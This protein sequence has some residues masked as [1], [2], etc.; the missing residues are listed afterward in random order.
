[1]MNKNNNQTQTCKNI[2]LM[3]GLISAACVSAKMTVI[4]DS[5][6][7]KSV[8]PYM[9]TVKTPN[10]QVLRQ[11]ASRLKP[12]FKNFSRLPVHTATLTPGKVIRKKIKQPHLRNPFFIV[13]AD[14]LSHQWL[15]E[16]KHQLKTLHAIGIAVNV[17]TEQQLEALQHSAGGI[18][19]NP[20]K[21]G[22]MAQQLKLTH[23][24]ALVSGGLI[25]Q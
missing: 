13:G 23:Y 10:M 17:Q 11:K 1:M 7:T 5:R 21:G 22:K 8:Q 20:V 2:I 16:N 19:I 15:I 24:P 6:L 25:E 14:R 12:D 3:V 18:T 4:Y 9:G